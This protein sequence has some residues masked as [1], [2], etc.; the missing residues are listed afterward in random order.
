[1]IRSN[2]NFVHGLMGITP[3]TGIRPHG[4]VRNM[5]YGENSISMI[6][7]DTSRAAVFGCGW[8]G[9]VVTHEGGGWVL[10]RNSLRGDRISVRRINVYRE[11]EG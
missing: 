5:K 8:R 11:Y 3:T 1:M 7:S 6:N 2:A 4:R 9:H 10:L